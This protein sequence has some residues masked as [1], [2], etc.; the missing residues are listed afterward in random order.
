MTRAARPRTLGEKRQQEACGVRLAAQTE[1]LRSQLASG[2][3]VAG[4]RLKLR[5]AWTERREYKCK[6]A[7]DERSKMF[8]EAISCD[9]SARARAEGTNVARNS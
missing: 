9:E 2:R 4:P 7:A 3:F 6:V 8:I 1:G 5:P